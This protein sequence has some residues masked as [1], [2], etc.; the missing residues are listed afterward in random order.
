MS[1]PHTTTAKN[2]TIQLHSVNH[3]NLQD[4]LHRYTHHSDQPSPL[5]TTT[6]TTPTANRCSRSS[7]AQARST[8]TR[9]R[10][11]HITNN[12]NFSNRR[13]S[14]SS[15]A[16]ARSTRTRSR[17]LHNFPRFLHRN[18]VNISSGSSVAVEWLVFFLSVQSTLSFIRLEGMGAG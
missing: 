11:L 16:Q 12:H 4:L 10:I 8:R 6:A 9:S 3:H 7:A 14:R 13:C 2:P 15:A 1:P 18:T 17:I 5:T